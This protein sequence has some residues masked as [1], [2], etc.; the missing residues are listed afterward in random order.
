MELRPEDEDR[1][2][3]IE[4]IVLDCDGVLTDGRLYFTDR[5]EEMKVF[6]VRDGYGLVLWRRA[7][8]RSAIIS[9]RRSPVVELRAKDLGID[10]VIQGREDKLTAYREL[11]DLTGTAPDQTAYMGDDTLDVPLFKVVGVSSAPADAHPEASMAAR[12][13]STQ[14]GGRGAVRELVDMIMDAKRLREGVSSGE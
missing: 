13:V 7:G 14:P 12:Y 6:D 4:L 5:G 10:F 1:C 11:M 8:F 3:R 2:G 9:G